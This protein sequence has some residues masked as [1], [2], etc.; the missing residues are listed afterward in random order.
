MRLSRREVLRA[1]VAAA[2]AGAGLGFSSW[3]D[4]SAAAPG[5]TT[6]EATLVLGAGTRYRSLAWGPGEPYV[7]RTDLG[8]GAG[9]GREDTR[10]ALTAFAHLTDAHV[11]DAQSPMRT[12]FLDR[13]F[14]ARAGGSRSDYR[15]HEMLTAHVADAMVRAVNEKRVAPATGARVAFALQTGD[16]SDNSQYNEIRWNIDILDGGPV[17]PDSGDPARWEGVADSAPR[18]WDLHY[19]HPE[20]PVPGAAF[21]MPRLAHGFPVVPGLLAAARRPFVAQ[22]L[23]VPWF[24]AFGNHD[25]LVGGTRPRSRSREDVAVG[26]RKLVS[27]PPGMMPGQLTAAAHADLES[28]LQRSARRVVRRVTA[29]PARRLLPRAD[30]VEEHFRTRGTP[31][32]HGFTE[33][34]RAEGTAYYTF[35]SGPVRFVV[36][37][38]VN[39][40]DGPHGSLDAA[41]FAW[42]ESQLAASRDRVVVLASHHTSATM[43]SPGLTGPPRVFGPRVLDLALS[44]P[45]VIAWVNGHKHHNRVWAHRRAGGGGLWEINTAA[46]VD[47]PLQ[48]RLIE[49]VDN[50]DGTL[51]IFATMLNHQ[52]PAVHDGRTSGTDDLASLARELAAN[53]WQSHATGR[54]GT[55][56][57]R[58]VELLVRSPPRR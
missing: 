21:D 18:W 12:E 39:P 44:H 51:S 31:V 57:D 56:A 38:S 30:L 54:E 29:D 3:S 50:R 33:R 40:D 25:Q 27:P 2:A 26:D 37:D 11:V 13:Y 4:A 32:G 48:S 20:G 49:I 1:G 14:D 58:N 24:T 8:V 10:Q 35:D 45:Q 53:D 52:G 15:P 55:R 47:W 22:G 46:H 6:L 16:G 17:T 28:L 36:L 42:L 19:W 5:G 23:R 34:N 43:D 7:V 9:A 41:Q